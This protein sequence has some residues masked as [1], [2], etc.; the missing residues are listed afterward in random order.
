MTV[1]SWLRSWA[2]LALILS[3]VVGITGTITL[4]LDIGHPFGGYASYSVTLDDVGKI[5]EETA[6]M[7]ST[8]RDLVN[9][10]IDKLKKARGEVTSSLGALR[11]KAVPTPAPTVST[12]TTGKK[13]RT[14]LKLK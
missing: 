9:R 8:K 3:A 13:K 1:P 7:C 6:L 10:G 11:M 5:T 14:L 12:P 4:V 2:G